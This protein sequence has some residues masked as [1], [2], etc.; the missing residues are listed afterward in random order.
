MIRDMG[1]TDDLR[2]A[3]E[4]SPKSGN[5]I[6]KEAGIGAVFLSRFRN[7]HTR[8]GLDVAERLAAAVGLELTLKRKRKS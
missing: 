8:I 6:A 1:I 7:K 2:Q 4:D 3:V 5:D